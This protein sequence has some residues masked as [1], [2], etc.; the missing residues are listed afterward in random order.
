MK[1]PNTHT[2]KPGAAADKSAQEVNFQEA[3]EAV[4][5]SVIFIDEN[6]QLPTVPPCKVCGGI[7]S[8]KDGCKF[9]GRRVEVSA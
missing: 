8:H 7:L 9:T 4:G 5:L 2:P 6:T 3:M 1:E